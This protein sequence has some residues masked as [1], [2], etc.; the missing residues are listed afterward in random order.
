VFSLLA[1]KAKALISEGFR[2]FPTERV[3][4]QIPD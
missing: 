2:A 4:K 1:Q 3:K